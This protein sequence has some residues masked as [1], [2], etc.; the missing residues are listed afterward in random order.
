M[1]DLL[2]GHARRQVSVTRL[3]I[4]YLAAVRGWDPPPHKLQ[5]KKNQ[6]ASIN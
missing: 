6:N 3:P 1:G 2:I 4:I 5:I